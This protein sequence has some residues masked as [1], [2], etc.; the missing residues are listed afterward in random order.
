MY[1]LLDNLR[2]H[3]AAR[4]GS[5]RNASTKLSS[6]PSEPLPDLVYRNRN[7]QKLRS[8]ICQISPSAREQMSLRLMYH[9]EHFTAH[10]LI[11]G[12]AFWRDRILPLALHVSA[13]AHDLNNRHLGI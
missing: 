2:E 13:Q 11:F 4:S 9:F 12:N 6:G 8:E 1:A 3:K 10:T 5:K 7:L